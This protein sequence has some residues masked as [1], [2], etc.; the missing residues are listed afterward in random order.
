VKTPRGHDPSGAIRVL[1]EADIIA[2]E[3]HA[4]HP[5]SARPL[6]DRHAA[7][8]ATMTTTGRKSAGPL[9][10]AHAPKEESV[11]L[12]SGS[13]TPGISDPAISLSRF[14]IDQK[15]TVVP[16]PGNNR[17]HCSTLVSGMPTDGAFRRF[18]LPKHLARQNAS[19]LLG[20]RRTH[21]DLLRSTAQDHQ[22]SRGY[23]RSS[24]R[25]PAVITGN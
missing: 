23:A 11:S 8:T 17:C 2:A 15:D 3:E 21:P 22:V 1:K 18:L 24:R 5:A 13:C 9:F 10:G 25:P 12:V 14:A 6:S 20:N 16:H 4:P 7:H 19:R